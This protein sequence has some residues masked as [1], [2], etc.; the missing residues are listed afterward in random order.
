MLARIFYI[1]ELIV[2][3]I[4]I[5]SAI[6]EAKAYNDTL[7]TPS[8]RQRTKESLL[9]NEFII[10]SA[11]ILAKEDM[12]HHETTRDVFHDTFEYR[13]D[14]DSIIPESFSHHKTYKYTS[15]QDMLSNTYRIEIDNIPHFRSFHGI[16]EKVIPVY[17]N[18]ND[19]SEIY[20]EEEIKKALSWT[21]ANEKA[22]KAKDLDDSKRTIIISIIIAIAILVHLI[23]F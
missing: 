6:L 2:L 20:S 10:T 1:A 19:T 15:Y 11:T 3:G 5:L 12:W 14:S 23:F 21:D 13:I 4:S 17:Y 18:K 9:T 7:K 16:S 22:S 8:P